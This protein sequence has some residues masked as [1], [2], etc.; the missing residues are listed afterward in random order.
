[1]VALWA[2]EYTKTRLC[3]LA[4]ASSLVGCASDQSTE[5]ENQIFL[6]EPGM[7]KSKVVQILGR[8]GDRQFSGE[9]QAW[10]YCDPEFGL[11]DFAIV[12][13][14][15]DV[16]AALQTW[17]TSPQESPY[18]HCDQLFRTVDWQDAPDSVIEIRHR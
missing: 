14:D 3:I 18:I 8:P 10:Q 6:I 12:W 2:K 9:R 4:V 13:F 1:M 16:V 7:N 5:L 17:K 15:G 11:D